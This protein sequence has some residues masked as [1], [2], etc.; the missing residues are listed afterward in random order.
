MTTGM[1]WLGSGING[2]VSFSG[3][4]RRKDLGRVAVVA[5]EVYYSRYVDKL[6]QTLTDWNVVVNSN[7]LKH[8][9]AA[10]WLAR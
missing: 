3:D 9:S 5:K 6:E 10:H 2:N 7:W 1:G 4:I 8:P